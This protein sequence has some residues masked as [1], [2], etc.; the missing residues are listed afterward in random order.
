MEYYL[1]TKKN[2]IMPFV[3][4]WVQLEMIIRSEIRQKEILYITYIWNLKHDTN[5]ISKKRNRLTDTENR[6][7]VANGVAWG[8]EGW[9]VWDS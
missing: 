4:A 9:G 7:V 8:R 3:G 5:K 1:T 2:E 6:P